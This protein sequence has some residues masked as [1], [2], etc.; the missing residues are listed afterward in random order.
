MLWPGEIEAIRTRFA[1]GEPP[2]DLAETFRCSVAEVHAAT[3]G[4][5]PKVWAEAIAMYDGGSS[6]ETI[7]IRLDLRLGEVRVAVGAPPSTWKAPQDGWDVLI[8]LLGRRAA[9]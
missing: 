1:L 2:H 6:V 7:A 9:A 8:R 5:S 4:V 3:R